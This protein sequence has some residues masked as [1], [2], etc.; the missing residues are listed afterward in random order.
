MSKL[1]N[2]AVVIVAVWMVVM[3]PLV[4]RWWMRLWQEEKLDQVAFLS[5][6]CLAILCA[7]GGFFIGGCCV[8][9]LVDPPPPR[10]P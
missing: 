8:F 6:F 7:V 1:I 3:A 2:I 9:R 4:G 10:N 5:A